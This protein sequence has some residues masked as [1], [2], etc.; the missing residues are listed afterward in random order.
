MAQLYELNARTI[1]KDM[2]ILRWEVLKLM[3]MLRWILG[4][5]RLDMIINEDIPKKLGKN[6]LEENE[7]ILIK[8]VCPNLM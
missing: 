5:A 6:N 8:I 2:N 1:K 7:G 4:H 3:R